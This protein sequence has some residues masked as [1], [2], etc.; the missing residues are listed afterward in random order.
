MRLADRRKAGRKPN[1]PGKHLYYLHDIAE[2]RC[3][4]VALSVRAAAKWVEAHYRP[5]IGWDRLAEL[6]RPFSRGLEILTMG[7]YHGKFTWM[8]MEPAKWLELVTK[9]EGLARQDSGIMMLARRVPKYRVSTR[10]DL[11][12]SLWRPAE[13]VELLKRVE[14]SG[15]G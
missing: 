11:P 1:A 7:S 5:G 3:Q 9:A 10:R 6:Y 2:I 14:E 4:R 8:D 15:G 13:L 12:F